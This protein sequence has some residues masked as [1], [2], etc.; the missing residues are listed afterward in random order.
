M[1]THPLNSNIDSVFKIG[2]QRVTIA[3]APNEES[4]RFPI[5]DEIKIDN[6]DICQYYE[7]QREEMSIP[8]STPR[9]NIPILKPF[10]NKPISS[11]TTTTPEPETTTEIVTTTEITPTRPPIR[12]NT[13]RPNNNNLKCGQRVTHQPQALITHG[14]KTREGL[15]PWHVAIYHN[16]KFSRSYVC[17]GSL[18]NRKTIL[19]AAHCIIDGNGV[20]I[21]ERISV[22]LG[23]F[24]LQV[25]SVNIQAVK[26]FDVIPHE[27]YD[28]ESFEHDIGILKLATYAQLNRYV[29]IICLPSPNAIFSNK[30]GEI[31][32]WGRNEDNL[33]QNEMRHAAMPVIDRITCLRSNRNHF[34]QYLTDTNF[35]AGNQNGK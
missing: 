29:Q 7:A 2:E 31:V 22:E 4:S 8:R 11:R 32:G 35:C 15:W 10:N 13:S 30:V 17:G 20:I 5:I 25:T 28:P 23:R 6:I 27:K 14:S 12:I 26:I 16:T 1:T 3:V 34:G 33:I 9:S 21:P 18:I 19:T 24:D